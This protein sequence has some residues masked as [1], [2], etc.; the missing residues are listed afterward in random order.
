MHLFHRSPDVRLVDVMGCNEILDIHAAHRPKW[1]QNIISLM[2]TL[3]QDNTT[4]GVS[5]RLRAR[6]AKRTLYAR[7]YINNISSAQRS[8]LLRSCQSV[9]QVDAALASCQHQT[10]FND[11]LN[12]WRLRCFVLHAC[13]SENLNS[14]LIVLKRI[15]SSLQFK[16][17]NKKL[18][19]SRYLVSPYYLRLKRV[20]DSIWK[21]EINVG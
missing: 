12:F 7:R 4:T 9:W 10:S 3:T 19:R 2:H 6:D 21:K 17:F 1:S 11:W 8:H 5:R 15:N 20:T 14:P 13:E 18:S 16:R